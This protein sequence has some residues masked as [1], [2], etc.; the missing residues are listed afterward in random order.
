MAWIRGCL[1]ARWGSLLFV[2]VAIVGVVAAAQEA[3][4]DL[5][6]SQVVLMPSSTVAS[7]EEAR[8]EVTVERVGPPLVVDARIEI[9]WR[10][11]DREE[12]C[13]TSLGVFP[14][15]EVEAT[16]AFTATLPTDGL[17]PGS[18][19][20]VV[21]VDPNRVVAESDETNNRLAVALELLPPLPELR[22]V[23]ADVVPAPPLWWGATGTLEALIENTGRASAG[24]FYVEF[25]LFPIYCVDPATGE[26][27]SIAP[28]SGNARGLSTWSFTADPDGLLAPSYA[29]LAGIVASLAEGAWIPFS[30]ALVAGLERDRDAD[31]TGTLATG[32]PLRILLT[33]SGTVDGAIGSSSMAVLSA[34]EAARVEKCVT[35]Y[36]IRIRIADAYGVDDEDSTNNVVLTALTVR[37][38]SLE[39][40]D[41]APIRVT[42][43]RAM[44]LNWDDDVDVEVEVTNRGGSVA[45]ASGSAGVGVSF[46][47]R[48]TG[49]PAWNLLVARTI[50]RLGID[51]ESDTD[52]VEAT[53]DAGPSQLN[54]EPGSYELRVVV[55]EAEGIVEQD[56]NNNE[57]V[58]GFSVQGTEIHPISLE[59]PATTVRQG[60]TVT[61]ASV[62][63]NTGERTLANFTVGFYLGDRRF[64]TFTYRATSTADPGLEEEDRARV[65]GTLDTADL[66]PGVYSL[67]VVADPDQRV[68]ELDET[69]NEI[70]SSLTILPPLERLAELL[71]SGVSLSPASPVPSGSLLTLRA[72]VRNG[73]TKDAEV[74]PVTFAVLR[75]DGTVW[76]SGVR[77]CS[78]A[79]ELQ[80]CSCNETPALARGAARVVEVA[81]WTAE[82]PEGQY[83]LHVWVDP[84]TAAS[85]SGAIRELDETN[86]EVV[87]SFTIGRPV[88]GA[89]SPQAN[90][91]LDAVT[92]EPASAPP[93]RASVVVLATLSNRGAQ[94]TEAFEVDI[95]WVRADGATV[96]LARPTAA[97]LGPAESLTL[98]Q[99][100]P[101]GSIAWTCGDHAFHVVVDATDAVVEASETDNVG[102]AAFR[103]D[104]GTGASHTADLTVSLSVP[105]ARDGKLTA[106]CPAAAEIVVAN[107]GALAAGSFRVEVRSGT[108]LIGSQD[109]AGLDAQTS[110]AIRIDLDTSAAATLA[111]TATAD[112]M[113]RVTEEDEA[114]NTA[115]TT[116]TVVERAAAVAT[117]IGGPY[118]AAVRHVVIDSTTGVVV[119]AADDGTLHAFT[120]G[121]PPLPLFDVTVEAGAAVADLALDRSGATRTAVAVLSTGTLHRIAIST[122]TRVG[123]AVEVGQTATALALDAA[124]TAFVGTEAGIS[125]VRRTGELAGTVALDGRVIDLALDTSGTVVYAVTASSLYAVSASS[126]SIVCTASGFG[127]QA[128]S[129][130]LGPSGIY[131]GTSA[132]RVLAFSPCASYGSMGTAMLR[133]WSAEASPSGAAVTALAVYAETAADPVYAATCE[134]GGGRVT[135]FSLAGQPLWIYPGTASPIG[136]VRGA[137]SVD[138]RRGRVSF[139]DASGIMTVLS[140]RGEVTLV[141]ES[142]A[143]ARASI[144]SAVAWDALLI[145]SD[146][147]TQFAELAYVGTQ[148]GALY[149]VETV[150]GGCP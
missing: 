98:R 17:A 24:P 133:S 26:T 91:V 134:P 12:P 109:V 143:T 83:T 73:G 127:A 129:L 39:L 94:P 111:L 19:E 107:G 35:T 3:L 76:S 79:G 42:F 126:R 96:S 29:G 31:V 148:E 25:S 55:D 89:L 49:S 131:V 140:D 21:V 114:N 119:A 67:R 112:A 113:N 63:E 72:T 16:A 68:A 47:Y 80:A 34:A 6:V 66:A 65:Q 53:L 44:P 56:E 1:A 37:P 132:G 54:L 7:G 99:E 36:G 121:S 4:P 43:D 59:I 137:L 20:V 77:D 124:G 95:R 150:R 9:T 120:R 2:G 146:G 57:I 110:T 118:G 100:V 15:G 58:V 22:I 52:V 128:T 138:R 60:D 13:G 87:T 71:V 90:L 28:G 62:V 45:P 8:A 38:S 14:A 69:N 116:V 50:V 23:R 92:V 51:E 5:R 88:P 27:W 10:R 40:P 70:R 30:S 84:P 125:I 144:A 108:A 130:A 46:Y 75:E 102:S 86:N 82:W 136:C 93:G 105:A 106:G 149:V 123:T 103:I 97:G 18:Y 104:C 117:R 85:S 141:D 33:T 61:I 48:R 32:Q 115:S 142:L 122:G 78:A 81:V 135:A 41:L 139:G 145:E 101:L 64:D 147:V 74:F 11:R